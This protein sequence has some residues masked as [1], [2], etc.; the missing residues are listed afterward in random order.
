MKKYN[1]GFTLIE[2][3]IVI[4]ILAAIFAYALPNYRQ[5]ILRSHRTEA[6]NALMQVSHM[7][8]RFYANKNRFGSAEE[9]ALESIFPTPTDDNGLYYTIGMESTATSYTVT[10]SAAGNQK[11]DT[12]CLKFSIDSLGNKKPTTNKCW[13]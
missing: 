11:D 13:D 3:M 8:E 12:K 1:N 10:A 4:A 2:L 5:Y 9:L 7:Q 6:Q